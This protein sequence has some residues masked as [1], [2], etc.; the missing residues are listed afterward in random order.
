[1]PVAASDVSHSHKTSGKV[2]HKHDES[3]HGRKTE[4]KT[5]VLGNAGMT[6]GGFIRG[7][8]NLAY[9]SRFDVAG[10]CTYSV[11]CSRPFQANL[12]P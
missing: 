3:Q 6:K 8:P 11:S 1:M 9:A 2:D 10:H 12:F 4:T 5:S 7:S